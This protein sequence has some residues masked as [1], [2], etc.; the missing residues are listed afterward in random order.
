MPNAAGLTFGNT[1][2]AFQSILEVSDDVISVGIVRQQFGV[3]A[4]ARLG[5]AAELQGLWVGEATA[6]SV[7]RLKMLAF[8]PPE[9]PEGGFPVARPFNFRLLAHVDA[10]GNARLLQRVFV[11]TRKDPTNGTI[12]TDLMATEARVSAYKAQYP[13]AKVFRYSSANFPFMDPAPLANGAFGVP[14]QVVLGSVTV[15]PTNAANPF[16]HAYSPLHNNKERRADDNIP[17]EDDVESFTVRRDITMIFQGPD[18]VNPDPRWGETVC[19]GVYQET[20]YGLGGPVDADNRTIRVDGRF[21]LQR[22]SPVGT[23]LQ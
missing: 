23:L 6:T 9:E 3:R 7:S 5:T 8:T 22:A 11:G 21:V 16:F 14:N 12:I 13:A 1:N 17:Y 18:Q 19:G 10:G 20:I 2:A 15:G 4:M